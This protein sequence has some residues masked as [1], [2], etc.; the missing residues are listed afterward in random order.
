MSGTSQDKIRGVIK[1][2]G[3]EK[4]VSKSESAASE[5]DRRPSPPRITDAQPLLDQDGEA[6]DNKDIP[7]SGMKKSE[8][9][10][11][12]I[13]ERQTARASARGSK[14]RSRCVSLH[15]H[16]S[17]CTYAQSSLLFAHVSW[18]IK[19]LG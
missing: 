2:V 12:W 9:A 11:N 15:T 3:L 10:R 1:E 7:M 6:P 16:T 19:I 13:A 17:L 8:D 4:K 14:L 5:R 18:M